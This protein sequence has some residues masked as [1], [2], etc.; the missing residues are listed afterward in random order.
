MKLI[1]IV[2]LAFLCLAAQPSSAHRQLQEDVLVDAQPALQDQ[3]VL[4]STDAASAIAA[5][6]TTEPDAQEAA[7]LLEA[8]STAAAAP[9]D[10]TA[11][12]PP[13]AR[14]GIE[15]PD[16][17]P[18][19]SKLDPSGQGKYQG[20]YRYD[21]MFRTFCSTLRLLLQQ[22]GSEMHHS[23][24]TGQCVPPQ[25]HTRCSM[26]LPACMHQWHHAL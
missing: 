14:A 26:M 6:V 18:G 22:P 9:F 15:V 13:G 19:P 10:P 16:R 12:P 17:I 5:S 20:V 11:N 25:Q 4:V 21:L 24:C 23:L 3:L 1:C 2:A 7:A 8:L